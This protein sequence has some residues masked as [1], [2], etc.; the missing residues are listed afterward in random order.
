MIA[1]ENLAKAAPIKGNVV[2]IVSSAITFH[3]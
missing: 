3:P 1:D 2:K